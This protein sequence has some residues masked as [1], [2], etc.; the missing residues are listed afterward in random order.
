MNPFDKDEQSAL[1]TDKFR[2]RFGVSQDARKSVQKDKEYVE[3]CKV[4]RSS[5]K[6]I[7]E[8]LRKIDEEVVRRFSKKVR[9]GLSLGR[10]FREA[11][12]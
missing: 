6:E 12:F 8:E 10:E 2:R 11:N 4:R 1:P 9:G 3:E 5:S 7:L